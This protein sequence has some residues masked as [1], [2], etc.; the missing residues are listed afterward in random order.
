[1][2]SQYMFHQAIFV[3][4]TM[5]TKSTLE[6]GIDAAFKIV[7][8]LQVMFVLVRLAACTTGMFETDE[9]VIGVRLYKLGTV[10]SL[11]FSLLSIPSSFSF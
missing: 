5:R 1:M 11:F 4:S 2:P 10:F 9:N 7:M 8:P 3:S 6:L